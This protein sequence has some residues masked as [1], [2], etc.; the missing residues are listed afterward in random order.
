MSAVDDFIRYRFTPDGEHKVPADQVLDYFSGSRE[1]FETNT[2]IVQ[3]SDGTYSLAIGDEYFDLNIEKLTT[4]QIFAQ[5]D[6]YSLYKGK[7]E[8]RMIIKPRQGSTR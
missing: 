6:H 1:A 3:W 2:K 5:H 8:Q 4:R 7:A